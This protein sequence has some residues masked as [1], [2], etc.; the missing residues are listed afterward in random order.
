MEVT[1]NHGRSEKG[2]EVYL[3][4][5][6]EEAG[7]DCSELKST[8]EKQAFEVRPSWLKCTGGRFLWR[9]QCPLFC[10]AGGW[11]LSC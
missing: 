7:R 3:R 11:R 2:D 5:K 1:G 8:G 9:V 6:D 4:E 10:W